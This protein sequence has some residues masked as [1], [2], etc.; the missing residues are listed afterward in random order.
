MAGSQR[1][2]HAHCVQADTVHSCRSVKQPLLLPEK[3]TLSSNVTLK[4]QAMMKISKTPNMHVQRQAQ[5]PCCQVTD[6]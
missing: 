5:A 4:S 3:T 2:T 6:A 1:Q